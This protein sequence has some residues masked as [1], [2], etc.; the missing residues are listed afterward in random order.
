MRYVSQR[1][2]I[3]P[4][5]RAM[6]Y[7]DDIFGL[8]DTQRQTCS[9]G[10]PDADDA[11]VICDVDVCVDDVVDDDDAHDEDDNADFHLNDILKYIIY[12]CLKYTTLM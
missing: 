1:H 9:G 5:L 2:S 6:S 10:I 11:D 8:L 3:E 12:I 7:G 4:V